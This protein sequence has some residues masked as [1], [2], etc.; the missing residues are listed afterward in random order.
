MPAREMAPPPPPEADIAASLP[1]QG[2]GGTPVDQPA[3]QTVA[4]AVPGN[5]QKLLP[6]ISTGISSGAA[7][8]G[9]LASTAASVAS[10]GAG[11]AGAAGPL[12]SGLFQ[13]GGKIVEGLANAGAAFASGWLNFGGTTTNPYGVQL[14][15]NEKPPPLATDQRR[16]HVGNNYFASMDD[17]RRR[18]QL[19][20]AQD[21]QA[22]LA[23]V[24]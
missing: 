13:Q 10:L 16:T 24:R 11:G 6:A 15:S 2:V 20:D 12:I 18:T 19:Q 22:S 23:R 9:N 14:R 3:P 4:P 5:E 7:T 17:W 8:L 1:P 21:Q